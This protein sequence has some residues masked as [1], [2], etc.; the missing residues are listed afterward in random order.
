MITAPWVRFLRGVVDVR[1][2][3]SEHMACSQRV[4]LL[5]LRGGLHFG[6]PPPAS[7]DAALFGV[8]VLQGNS[9]GRWR[10]V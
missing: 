10:R 9:G 3:R 8:R 5:S 4:G 1:V 2:P 6:S 7:C